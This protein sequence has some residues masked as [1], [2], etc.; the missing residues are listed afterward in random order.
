[1]FLFLLAKL[2][3]Y[4]YATFTSSLCGV[5]Q[6]LTGLVHFFSHPEYQDDSCGKL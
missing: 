5:V 1:V 3:V 4:N 6:V 2:V